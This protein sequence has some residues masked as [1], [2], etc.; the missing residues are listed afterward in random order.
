MS[1]ELFK[2]TDD[3]YILNIEAKCELCD[4]TGLYVGM[5]ERKGAAVI[6]HTCN[7]TGKVNQ[8]KIFK[9][10]KSKSKRKDVK[11]VFSSACGYIIS[12]E[13]VTTNEGIT[14]EF[15]KCGCSYD[16]WLKGETPKPIEDLHC[17][18]LH[19]GQSL[20]NQEHPQHSVYLELCSK[21]LNWGNI[22]DCKCYKNKHKC[23]KKYYDAGGK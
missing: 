1:N 21:H 18:Y 17:P 19:T 7:G 8:K 15:S 12:A 14:I 20:Q 9:K 2:E 22:S 6:C 23:W 16:E 11:R 10:F 3:S 5:A 13:D 4:G